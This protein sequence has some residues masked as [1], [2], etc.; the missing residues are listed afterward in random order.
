MN[1]STLTWNEGSPGNAESA[2]SGATILRSLETS[3]RFGFNDEHHWPSAGG[4]NVGY[5]R[6]GAAR[7]FIGTQSRVSSSGSDGRLMVTSDTSRLFAVGS[8]GT[9]L[10]GGAT[11]LSFGSFPGATPQT[12][13][14][15]EEF[16]SVLLPSSGS[17]TIIFP[18]S[19]F[20]GVPYTFVTSYSIN[21]TSTASPNPTASINT[22][23]AST[24]TQVRVVATA[25]FA[26]GT[27]VNTPTTLFWRSIG[28]RVF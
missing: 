18:N 5:H 26:A 8:G 19:G 14:W 23:L 10:L 28:S 9:V 7:P 17:T 4:D 27:S 11:G 21:S 20:S 12:H 15:A 2:G 22:D 13:Y 16:G 1:G 24:A 6:F 3:L 25:Q